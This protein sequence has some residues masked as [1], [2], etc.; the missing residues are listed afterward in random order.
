MRIPLILPEVQAAIL[1]G[2]QS[3][4]MGQ[5]KLFLDYRG[6][7]FIAHL[8]IQLQQQVNEVVVAGAPVP[9]QLADLGVPVLED[10]EP[11]LGPLGGVAT[12]LKHASR[13]WLLTAPCDNP[14][15]PANF[16]TRLLHVAR[17]QN[18]PLVYVRKA[19]KPQPLYAIVRRDLL[20]SLN[21]YLAGGERKVMPWY[22]S[23]DALALDWDDAGVSFININ[24][25][26]EYAAFLDL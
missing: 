19:R 5:H 1:A 15:L 9:R 18:V 23:V 25:P 21:A 20:G 10:A 17:E 16:A 22:E 12:A 13:E 14:V 3:R 8:L 26:E 11:D 6:N 4:R 2:G 24:T 7:T